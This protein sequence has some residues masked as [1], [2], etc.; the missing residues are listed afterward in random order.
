MP[1]STV[2][3]SILLLNFQVPGQKLVYKF[4]KLPYEY[5]PRIV[6]IRHAKQT[7]RQPCS[8]RN[9]NS[10]Q[11]SSSMSARRD[12]APIPLSSSSMFPPFFQDSIQLPTIPFL[13]NSPC[14]SDYYQSKFL[15]NSRTP[16]QSWLEVAKAESSN[17]MTFPK[18][19]PPS[20]TTVKVPFSFSPSGNKHSPLPF[21]KL[22]LAKQRSIPVSVITKNT[23]Q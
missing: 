12:S 2:T 18:S 10:P 9:D 17:D 1:L 15:Y 8:S 11:S 7:Q 6:N 20:I 16:F 14:L 4:D 22:K 21:S 23:S 13:V 5:K 19:A 3:H